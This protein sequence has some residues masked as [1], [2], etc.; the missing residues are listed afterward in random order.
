MS[1]EITFPKKWKELS[2]DEQKEWIRAYYMPKTRIPEPI[3]TKQG[4]IKEGMLKL[5]NG[6]RIE[7]PVKTVV[8][9]KSNPNIVREFEFWVGKWLVTV[10]H[11]K[12]I[13]WL[14]FIG[15]SNPSTNKWIAQELS[16]EILTKFFVVLF[17]IANK[18]RLFQRK[19]AKSRNKKRNFTLSLRD[20]R[21]A[22]SHG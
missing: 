10:F 6:A 21:E 2:E 14:R 17:K 12:T 18:Y 4:R 13:P 9:S 8:V 5:E 15:V 20:N 22:V 16:Y 11:D 7:F 3:L 19:N 1:E